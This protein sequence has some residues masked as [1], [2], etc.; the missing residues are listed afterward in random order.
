V[1]TAYTDGEPFA[2]LKEQIAGKLSKSLNKLK[3]A[4]AAVL[5][6]LQRRL[7]KHAKSAR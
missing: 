1:I 6:L 7:K 3:P 4:E 5:A 2:A